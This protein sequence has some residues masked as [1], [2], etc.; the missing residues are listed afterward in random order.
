MESFNLVLLREWISD[1]GA[2]SSLL[3]I[4]IYMN[5]VFSVKLEI[6]NDYWKC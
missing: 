5:Y 2:I 1:F 4:L 3:Y 6:M